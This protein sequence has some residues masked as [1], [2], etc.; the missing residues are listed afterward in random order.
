MTAGLVTLPDGNTMYFG[1][2]GRMQTG[3]QLIGG[4]WFFFGED[5]VLV[6]NAIFTDNAG[7]GVQVDANGLLVVPEGYTPQ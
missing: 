5:G 1:T 6:R 2:D 4:G 3:W 7:I